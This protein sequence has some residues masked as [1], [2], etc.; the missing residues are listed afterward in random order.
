MRQKYDWL[1]DTLAKL[2]KVYHEQV[3]T[4]R[5][6]K[7]WNF[8]NNNISNQITLLRLINYEFTSELLK[9]LDDKFKK[10]KPAK[11]E[12]SMD[13][14]PLYEQIVNLMNDVNKSELIPTS[15]RLLWILLPLF[16]F[17][18]EDNTTKHQKSSNQ[19]R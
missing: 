10:I 9:Q 8:E 6:L 5:K 13:I 14:E 15:W 18:Q 12:E 1:M 19:I 16:D 2:E 3:E 4:K 17:D 11:S 7:G